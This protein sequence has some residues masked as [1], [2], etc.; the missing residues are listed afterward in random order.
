MTFNHSIWIGPL[1]TFSPNTWFQRKTRTNQSPALTDYCP[2]RG[3]WP[4]GLHQKT[5]IQA[6]K[7]KSKHSTS[8]Q[9]PGD[10]LFVMNIMYSW[11]NRG[12]KI[13]AFTPNAKKA[14]EQVEWKHIC[15]VMEKF[16]TCDNFTSC[17]KML[18]AH[19]AASL[20]THFNT[21]SPFKHK[22][23]NVLFHHI[24]FWLFLLAS[25]KENVFFNYLYIYFIL[26]SSIFTAIISCFTFSV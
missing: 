8:W 10:S 22:R 26:F 1:P 18:F 25:L 6:G 24:S 21:S 20:R 15:A 11:H 3:L 12:A 9:N 16:N 17:I 7:T 14:F 23:S 19:R 5:C 4:Q 2:P 13:A